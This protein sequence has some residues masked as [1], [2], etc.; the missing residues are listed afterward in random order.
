MALTLDSNGL[1]A[2]GLQVRIATA[3]VLVGELLHRRRP[4]LPLDV[5]CGVAARADAPEYVAGAAAGLRQLHLAVPGDDNAP[6][7][8]L[9]TRLMRLLVSRVRGQRG[10]PV[11]E[12]FGEG[13]HRVSRRHRGVRLARTRLLPRVTGLMLVSA[14][15]AV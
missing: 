12:F 8:T 15:M 2:G 7:P 13:D 11:E 3:Q 4:F 9:D 6:A 1:A 14:S 5:V 10:L